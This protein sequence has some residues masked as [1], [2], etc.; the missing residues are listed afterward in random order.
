[1]FTLT[2]EASRAVIRGWEDCD[3]NASLLDD[4][5]PS[6]VATHRSLFGSVIHFYI[7]WCNYVITNNRALGEKRSSSE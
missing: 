2:E 5:T 7:W 4:D 1:M 3:P 6:L